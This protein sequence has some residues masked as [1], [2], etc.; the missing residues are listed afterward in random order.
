MRWIG[1]GL[2]LAFACAAAAHAEA[3]EPVETAD[4][5]LIRE[6]VAWPRILHGA[7]GLPEWLDLALEQ[8]T[9][10]EYLD[11]PFR[12]GEADTQSQ[13][14]QRTRLR[15]GV[16]AP[17]GF[18]FLAEL[19]D[20]RTWGEGPDEFTGG[21]IDKLSFAQLFASWTG[22]DVL[23]SGQRVDL[24]LG[25][26][27]LD[28]GSRRLVARNGFRNTTNA[29][30]G[31][32]LSFGDVA[33]WRARAF[34]TRP[35]QLDPSWFENESEGQQR[36]WGAA[37]EDRRIPWLNVDVYFLGLHDRL[38]SGSTLARRHHTFG[39]RALRAPKP[40]QWDYELEAVGQLGER[41]VTRAGVATRL[42]HEA[43]TG[44]A[45]VGYTFA[46]AWSPRLALQFD[47][48]SGTADPDSDESGSFDPLFGARRGD[49]MPTGIYG[50]FRRSNIASPG[51]RLQLSPRPD[52]RGFVKVRRWRLAQEKD[53][54]VGSGLADP[55]G[56]AGD[57]LGTDLE[58]S[59]QWTPRSWLL[60]EAGWD[61]WWKGSYLDDVPPPAGGAPSDDDSDYFYFTVQLRI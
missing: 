43:Y 11:E 10:F 56:G 45:E 29:F 30:D 7:L 33:R 53:A 37:F 9:R 55:S 41:R 35:V 32:H 6:D 27:S 21:T 4:A 28:V 5:Q 46:V 59:L 14:P 13:Y 50:P 52:L 24:H 40:A 57:R 44:H 61:H 26:M 1:C 22:R 17:A 60:L 8:R 51:L 2:A 42:D 34:W 16:D 18:R 58:L 48:A 23:G 15:L 31:V 47:Y 12:P 3:R 36:F 54:F 25:R 19:Q 20:S 38:G 49:L 39:A